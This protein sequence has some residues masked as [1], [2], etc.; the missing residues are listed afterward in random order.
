M[1][2]EE[3]IIALSCLFLCQISRFGRQNNSRNILGFL[4]V[5]RKH[6]K[7]FL[8]VSG[9]KKAVHKTVIVC[10]GEGGGEGRAAGDEIIAL[11]VDLLD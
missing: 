10:R 9:L 6:T 4:A 1:I 8:G 3:K 11:K 7:C 5:D 2:S